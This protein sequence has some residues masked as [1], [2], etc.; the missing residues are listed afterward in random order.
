MRGVTSVTRIVITA[1]I[2]PMR[3]SLFAEEN[4][5]RM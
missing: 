4:C 2:L 3:A 1:S 5:V